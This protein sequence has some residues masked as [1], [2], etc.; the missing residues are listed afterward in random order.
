MSVGSVGGVWMGVRGGL[1]RCWGVGG[2]DGCKGGW[3][4]VREVGWVLG[5]GCCEVWMGV[6][7]FEWVL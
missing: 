7:R 1:D 3:M 5:G 4:G 2:L 6:V